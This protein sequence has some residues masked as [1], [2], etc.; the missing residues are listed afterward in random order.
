MQ[1]LHV[2]C[3]P[4]QMPGPL[5]NPQAAGYIKAVL[6]GSLL[7]EV[8]AEGEKAQRRAQRAASASG[9]PDAAPAIAAAADGGGFAASLLRVQRA[10]DA[11]DVGPRVP[12]QVLAS[13]MV[14]NVELTS[15]MAG[16]MQCYVHTLLKLVHFPCT[17]VQ[18]SKFKRARDIL[19]SMLSVETSRNWGKGV[20]RLVEEGGVLALAL[21]SPHLAEPMAAV[22]SAE[23]QRE[24]AATMVQ[25]QNGGME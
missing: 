24:L 3:C 22:A 23:G 6:R 17:L 11:E 9:A 21:L 12:P 15:S 14:S 2:L 18:G 8:A 1:M 25:V 16:S 19:D 13:F 10:F 4:Q 20:S 7:V 5:S